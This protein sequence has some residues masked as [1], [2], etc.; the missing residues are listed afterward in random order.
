MTGLAAQTPVPPLPPMPAPPVDPN[1]LV[2]QLVPLIGVLGAL[3]VGALML[4]WFF[5]SPVWE[6]LAERMRARTQQRLGDVG[7]GDDRRVAAL[8]DHVHRLQGQI[9]EL[10]ERVDFAERILAEHRAQ[11]LGAGH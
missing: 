2:M 1:L 3:I 11:R 10:A 9:G 5:R 6:A 7:M 8:E 4:R